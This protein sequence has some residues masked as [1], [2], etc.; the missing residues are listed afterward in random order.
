MA[1]NSEFG[2]LLRGIV[3]DNNDPLKMGRLKIRIQAAYGSQPVDNLP[4][5][6]P[7]FPYGGNS[8]MCM[9]AIP[10]NGAG[11]WV[12]FQSKDGQPDTT[13]PVWLGVWQAQAE[14]L[15]EIEGASA[16]AHHYKELKTTSG[17]Y[18]L[19]CDKPHEEFIELRHKSGS[20]I[21]MD[22][23]GNVEIHAEKNMKL[24]AQRID[25]N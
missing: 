11:V 17:H 22:K 5:A 2:G 18:I 4:W 23:D 24:T 13:Y 6:F 9:Y 1:D 10:E 7:C 25:L 12:M 14:V 16:D 21:L 20:Y 3:I 15:S 19:F 8:E